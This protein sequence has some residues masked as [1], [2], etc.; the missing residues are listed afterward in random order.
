MCL[1]VK[2]F[3]LKTHQSAETKKL[4]WKGKQGIY[5]MVARGRAECMNDRKGNGCK[6]GVASTCFQSHWSS[7]NIRAHVI[8]TAPT[9][10]PLTLKTD[11]CLK[12]RATLISFQLELLSTKENSS[13]W[14]I[15]ENR[16]VGILFQEWDKAFSCH[17]HLQLTEV[18][19]EISRICQRTQ[20]NPKLPVRS[21]ADGFFYFVFHIQVFWKLI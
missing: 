15:W 3:K 12:P 10:F 7:V 5:G 11:H 17:E 2:A 20:A 16:L 18:K 13:M 19:A 14:S 1:N 4:K 6:S 21:P 9:G 8:P